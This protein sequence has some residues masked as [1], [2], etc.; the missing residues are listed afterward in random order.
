MYKGVIKVKLIKLTKVNNL[1][2]QKVIKAI[3]GLGVLSTLLLAICG[4]MQVNRVVAKE[5][6]INRSTTA[7][8]I[9]PVLDIIFSGC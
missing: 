2:K 8:V 1:K 5:F 3:F 9:D 7:K 6:N 4:C